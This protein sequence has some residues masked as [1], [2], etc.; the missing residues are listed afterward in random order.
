MSEKALTQ[1]KYNCQL[2]EGNYVEFIRGFNWNC[3]EFVGSISTSLSR[4]FACVNRYLRLILFTLHM[5]E[6]TSFF[7]VLHFIEVLLFWGLNTI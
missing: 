7:E 3:N 4:K 1:Y 2:S 6:T 5:N